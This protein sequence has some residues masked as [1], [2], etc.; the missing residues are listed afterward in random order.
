MTNK[1][2]FRAWSKSGNRWLK[3]DEFVIDPNGIPV[4][5]GDCN[6]FIRR[7]GII[8]MQYVGIKDVNKNYIFEG[9]ILN[10]ESLRTMPNTGTYI[11]RHIV[12]SLLEFSHVIHCSNPDSMEII[13]NIYENPEKCE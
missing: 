8:V 2:K 9:D 1:I 5:L 4:E 3:F 7:G 11:S 13:G 6:N 12:H 10:I